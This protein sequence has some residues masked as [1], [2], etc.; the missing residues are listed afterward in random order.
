MLHLRNSEFGS[1]VAKHSATPPPNYV[2]PPGVRYRC[3]TSRASLTVL[4][5]AS[6][7]MMSSAVTGATNCKLARIAEWPVRLSG[8]HILVDGAINSQKIGVMLDTG[9]PDTLILRSAATRL[10][11]LTR[12][13][14]GSRMFG[15]GGETTVE[16]T[17]VDDFNLGGVSANGFRLLVVGE[18]D[19]GE[20]VAVVIGEDFLQR[21]DVEFDLARRVVRLH[22]PKDCDSVS[23][24][25]WTKEVAGEVEIEA[26][27]EYRPRINLTVHI[28]GQPIRAMLDSGAASSV[29]T[30]RDAASLGVTPETPG[31]VATNP[32]GGLGA[33]SVDTW[34]GPF[35]S[36]AIGNEKIS[37]VRIRFA[38]LYK[39]TTYTQTGTQIRRNASA[40]QPMLLG[41]DFISAH[42]VLVSHS[43][44]KLY[45]TYAGGPVF[46]ADRPA[47]RADPVVDGDKSSTSAGK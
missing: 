14:K 10:G 1:E 39:D 25:Y 7:V 36:F 44:R 34:I 45:F 20:K 3:R 5:A 33:K 6:V 47:A 30:L 26:I 38:D 8:N 40:M 2:R 43:Q 42:R 46:A 21:F 35:Q 32:G 22:Q 15:I 4:L 11:L 41:A 19:F 37:D 16:V 12:E 23:L 9:A 29:L 13:V 18:R 31:V 27:D 17:T 28:N 24:A